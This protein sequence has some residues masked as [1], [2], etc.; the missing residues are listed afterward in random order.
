MSRL[1]TT[2]QVPE[3]AVVYLEYGD[4]SSMTDDEVAAINEWLEDTFP[5]TGFICDF[6]F[7][8]VTEFCTHPLWGLPCKTITTDFYEP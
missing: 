1:I 5:S 8:D 6:H 3:W 2:E 7:D 4:S